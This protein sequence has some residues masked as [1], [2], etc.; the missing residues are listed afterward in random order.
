MGCL[1]IHNITLIYAYEKLKIDFCLFFLLL[2]AGNHLKCQIFSKS[3]SPFQVQN[4]NP[5]PKK[6]VISFKALKEKLDIK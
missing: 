5:P 2:F 1:M 3:Q 4:F 6:S